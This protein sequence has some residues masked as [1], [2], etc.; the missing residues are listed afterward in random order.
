[1]NRKLRILRGAAMLAAVALIVSACGGGGDSG[2]TTGGT[3]GGATTSGGNLVIWTGGG[4]GGEATKKLGD[5]FGQQ[6]GVKVTVQI[7][8]DELRRSTSRHPR[9]ARL[10]TS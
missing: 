6:N 3:T 9:P 10:P 1:M 4:P 5:A 7:V 8:P 2:G